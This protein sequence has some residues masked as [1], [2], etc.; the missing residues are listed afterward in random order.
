MRRWLRH[1]VGLCAVAGLLVLATHAGAATSELTM[2][3]TDQVKPGD[4][5]RASV[6][7]NVVRYARSQSFFQQIG[8]KGRVHGPEPPAGTPEFSKV[9]EKEPAKYNSEHPFRG[10]AKLG[11]QYFG[12]V[13]DTDPPK[14]P[15][16]EKKADED[17]T[18]DD[19]KK[20]AKEKKG[21]AAALAKAITAEARKKENPD[22]ATYSRLYFDLNHNGDLTDDKVIEAEKPRI[23]DFGDSYYYN[24]SFPVTNVTIDVDGTKVEYA[25][26]MRAGGQIGKKMSSMSY[27][28]ASLSAAAFREGKITFDGKDYV[29]AL[30]DFNS[31][32]RFDDATEIPKGVRGPRG[33]VYPTPG[34]MLYLIDAEGKLKSMS[35]YDPTQND[36][37]HFVGKL[38]RVGD[39]F[40]GLKIS[41]AGDELTIDS[42]T[43]PVGFV[44][45][46]NGDYQAI[47]YG[48][49][50]LLK[51][52]GDDSG[53]APLPAG[54]WKLM[55]YTIRHVEQP[56]EE[57]EAKDEEK[58]DDSS[59]ENA[60]PAKKRPVRPRVSIV[61]ARA[62]GDYEPVKVV[63]GETI[64]L[65]FGGPYKPVVDVQYRSGQNSVS[66]GL[67]LTGIVGESCSDM[68]INGRQPAE[69]TF[70]ITTADGKEVATGKFEYG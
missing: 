47:V 2:K 3:R 50:G 52:V 23:H 68:E 46:P 16:E 40:H 18:K 10:V 67:T 37:A 58:K 38:V 26:S 44:S 15:K 51:A 14:K 1:G 43:V 28:N 39:G 4:G 60:K 9:I 27:V 65:P 31:N 70:I 32:G 30:V 48:P 11:S 25:F 63:E 45:N 29:V 8:G 56:K 7:R 24:A 62:M 20:D 12:F 42:E 61:S 5:N 66:L 6:V 53:K 17:K 59:K 69:P 22:V 19:E 34:D 36:Y 49:G 54:E 41:P 57:P 21:F 13:F 55:A 33:S 64:E 35:P